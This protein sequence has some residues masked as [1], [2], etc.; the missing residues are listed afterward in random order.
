MTEAETIPTE[1]GRDWPRAG[2]TVLFL[3]FYGAVQWLF[4]AIALIQLIWFLVAKEPNPHLARFGASLGRWLDGIASYV[5]MASEEKPFP[6]A[7]W[8]SA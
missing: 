2:Y 5:F 3:I 8:P 1:K 6:W 4:G 7:A